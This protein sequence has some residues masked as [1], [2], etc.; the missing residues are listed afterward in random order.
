MTHVLLLTFGL[1]IKYFRDKSSHDHDI[2]L[3]SQVFA[4][5]SF[6]IIGLLLI[7]LLTSP[8]NSSQLGIFPNDKELQSTPVG[9]NTVVSING[10]NSPAS[11]STTS[12]LTSTPPE[13]PSQ[14]LNQTSS[15]TTTALSTPSSTTQSFQSSPGET[16]GPP[17]GL[18]SDGTINSLIT[19]PA[20]KWIA[21]GNWSMNLVNGTVKLFGANMTW[22]NSSGTAAHSHEFLNFTGD[23]GRVI[24]L[25]KPGNNVN[26]QGI[27]DV[28]TNNRVVWHAVPT[29]IEIN[30]KKT[31]T[32]AVD[33]QST[34]HHFASQPILGVV[35]TFVLCS[36]IPGANM[37]VLPPCTLEVP[38]PVS[39][40]SVPVVSNVSDF[41]VVNDTSTNTSSTSSSSSGGNASAGSVFSIYENA[42]SGV[43]ISYPPDW[44]VEQQGRVVSPSLQIA[45]KFLPASD[46]DS[47][48]TIG[49]RKLSKSD[50]SKGIEVY[51]TNAINGYKAKIN[52][53]QSITFNTNGKLSN[54]SG[55]EIEGTYID[56]KS[57]KRHL[58]EVGTI[59]GNKVYILQFDTDDL[60]ASTY[61]PTLGTMV[62]S[63]QIIGELQGSLDE[64]SVAQGIVSSGGSDK[65]NNNNNNDG[66]SHDNN[67][68]NNNNNNNGNSHHSNHKKSSDNNKSSNSKSSDNNNNNND[69]T[70]SCN[71]GSSGSN[72]NDG[73]S[74]SDSSS[75][76]DGSNTDGGDSSSDG[77]SSSDSSSSSDG[78]SGESSS[79]GSS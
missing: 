17:I 16:Q 59:V 43:K 79:D 41:S 49:I 34:N 74:S 48:F 10:S 63:F 8:G 60:K 35:N 75:S 18:V 9:N 72:C 4:L 42:T 12:P 28:G 32:I 51:A 19:T 47:H 26:I 11:T 23:K 46:P 31:I 29:T 2:L 25:Q 36:D 62:H 76:S 45:L 65:S 78:S 69:G 13:S 64:N 53:F 44:T 37:E 15:A 1:Y 20:T 30:G 6:S 52:N 70:T 38:V 61:L 33:D 24:S 27:M 71:D 39:T 55:Y 66:K 22:Y 21:T 57:T 56:D 3:T 67:N 14:T 7:P 73:S 40:T 50:A 58:F 54:N 5:C 77:S 68:N